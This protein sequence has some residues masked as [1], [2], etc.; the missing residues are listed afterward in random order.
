MFGD[1]VIRMLRKPGFLLDDSGRDLV[2]HPA[3][4][5]TQQAEKVR[6]AI[7]NFHQADRQH[8]PFRTLLVGTTIAQI[9]CHPGNTA[10]FAK[11]AELRY[12]RLT[13]L[14]LSAGISRKVGKTNTRTTRDGI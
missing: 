7:V 13:G 1:G 9:D 5:P 10:M 2:R 11:L 4:A 3:V 6:A 14:S 8:L 12:M